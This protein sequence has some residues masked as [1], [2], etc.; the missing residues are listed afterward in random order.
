MRSY[1][2]SARLALY[3]FSVL[4]MVLIVV[5]Y[6]LR[7][8]IPLNGI[9][10]AGPPRSRMVNLAFEGAAR[11]FQ[12]PAPLLKAVCYMEGR[13]SNNGGSPSADNGYGC[14][15]LI[16]NTHGDQLGRAARALGVSTN[17][18]KLD[19]P[20]NIRGGAALL[21]ADALRLS[22]THT[23]PASLNGWYGALAAYSHAATRSTA[24]MYAQA[25]YTQIS[26]GF[27]ARADDGETVALVPR[28]VHPDAI[29]AATVT[30]TSALPSGCQQDQN[31]DYPQAVDCV[32]DQQTFDCNKTPD[33][34][35]CTYE[36][37]QRPTDFA[38]D[39]IVIH[40]IEGTAQAS[41]NVFQN[42]KTIASAHYIIDSDGTIYQVIREKDIA[43][44]AGNYWYNEHSIGIEHAGIDATGYRWY[45]A[46]E[47]LAS[48]RLVA[49]LLKKYNLSLTHD[50]IVS[51][52]T[53]PSPSASSLPN[54]VDPGP[55]WLWS[56]YIKL[57][58]DQ[59]VPYGGETVAPVFML[60]PSSARF[61][62]GQDGKE[63]SANFN[64]FYLYNGPSTA[65]GRVPQLGNGHDVTDVSGCVEPGVSYYYLD[66]V[67][68]P[69]GSGATM[70][71]IW[72]GVVD[73]PTHNKRFAHARQAWLAV[74]RD[75]A[76]RGEGVPITLH[77]DP[78]QTPLIYG[79]PTTSSKY[80]LG[81]APAGATFVSAYTVTEDPPPANPPAPPVNPPGNSNSGDPNNP[82]NGDQDT[83]GDPG[84]L[85]DFGNQD[86][87]DIYGVVN[88]KGKFHRADGAGS[89]WYEINYNHR[90][91]WVPASEVTL[92]PIPGNPAPAR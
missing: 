26:Q 42:V 34:A 66:R 88:H 58:H 9:M 73:H 31:V 3:G 16:Q 54:H 4:V 40:D 69:A 59:G 64:F 29:S 91:A 53:I 92:L 45:S 20:T 10:L 2:F 84:F 62:L 44:H 11:E 13:L 6:E 41:L 87:I 7:A 37:A 63:T 35:P 81:D 21:R 43:Y 39:Q 61:P 83:I 15:H 70:Y 47:Y 72:F 32:V 74:P 80:V 90:Q 86:G 17:Q 30:G 50:R 56:Y 51:H 57:I 79:E 28:R 71:K 24:L 75:A 82:N 1:S 65:S 55:Y 22:P 14:M 60:R 67:V 23:L 76:A 18:L 46:S 78:G 49:Y 85:G 52:G 5:V 48:A 8:A 77:A 25:V 68:D 19:L 89:L 38:I 12:V 36:D 33:K 27:R